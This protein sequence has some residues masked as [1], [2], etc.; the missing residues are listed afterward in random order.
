MIFIEITGRKVTGRKVGA[1]KPRL[2]GAFSAK[3]ALLRQGKDQ[4]WVSPW[5]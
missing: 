5:M 3:R 4:I 2:S 1:K